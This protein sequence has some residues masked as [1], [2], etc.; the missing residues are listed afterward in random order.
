[1]PS[2]ENLDGDHHISLPTAESGLCSPGELHWDSVIASSS[3]SGMNSMDNQSTVLNTGSL[4]MEMVEEWSN[5][6]DSSHGSGDDRSYQRNTEEDRDCDWLE[7][8][9]CLHAKL[10]QHERSTLNFVETCLVGFAGYESSP[11]SIQSNSSAELTKPRAKPTCPFEKIFDLSM[12]LLLLIGKVSKPTDDAN[13]AENTF[14]QFE[15]SFVT[16]KSDELGLKSVVYFADKANLFL[17]FSCYTRLLGSFCSV[18]ECFHRIIRSSHTESSQNCAVRYIQ[19]LLPRIQMG[20]VTLCANPRFDLAMILNSAENTL[21]ELQMSMKNAFLEK[22]VDAPP[23]KTPESLV[24]CFLGQPGER[25]SSTQG[26]VSEV[27]Q[28]WETTIRDINSTALN[29]IKVL[30][31]AV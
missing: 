1:M 28:I 2:W 30:K 21:N 22:K 4:P 31:E 16:G 13:R 9:F 7:A 29:V 17:L 5:Q 6:Q 20:D 11:S 14:M 15:N 10:G 24:G 18:F 19:S 23:T 8:L 27:A 26:G 12:Q 3:L 25:P